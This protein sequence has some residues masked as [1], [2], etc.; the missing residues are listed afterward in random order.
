LIKD[1]SWVLLLKSQKYEVENILSA[2]F[3]ICKM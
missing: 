3:E 2:T 1:M